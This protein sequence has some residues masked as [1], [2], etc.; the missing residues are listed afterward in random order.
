VGGFES[1]YIS[2]VIDPDAEATAALENAVIEFEK[3][4]GN[5]VAEPLTP[6]LW[7]LQYTEFVSE[8]SEFAALAQKEL[9]KRLNTRNRG[10]RQGQFIVLAGVAMPSILVEVGFISNRVEEAQ[11]KTS[12]FRNKCAAAL[13]AAITDFKKRR[14]VRLGLLKGNSER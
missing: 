5:P 12:D 11:L 13:A 6:I 2:D 3:D 9:A 4:A 14:D 7:D 10:I 1:F 8:S